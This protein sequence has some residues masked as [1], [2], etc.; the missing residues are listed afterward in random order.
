M[1]IIDNVGCAAKLRFALL[2]FVIFPDKSTHISVISYIH[3]TTC[4]TMNTK[5]TT[6]TK[7]VI[8]AH[9]LLIV[10]KLRPSHDAK[11]VRQEKSY[12]KYEREKDRYK[13]SRFL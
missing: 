8:V 13:R 6:I 7:F 11:F 2:Y 10:R 3:H 9:Q 4:F 5:N 1:G 12:V